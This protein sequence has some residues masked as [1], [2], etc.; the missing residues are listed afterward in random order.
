MNSTNALKVNYMNDHQRRIMIEANSTRAFSSSCG[1][2]SIRR[3]ELGFQLDPPLIDTIVALVEKSA[4]KEP[5]PVYLGAEIYTEIRRDDFGDSERMVSHVSRDRQWL[6]AVCEANHWS[7][8]D[9][10]WLK[11]RI[12]IYDPEGIRGRLRRLMITNV[13]MNF[14][15]VSSPESLYIS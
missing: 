6:L 1:W 12:S 14:F 11:R 2:E 10:D 3:L 15:R 4:M 8:M 13:S 7:A 5:R 9:I